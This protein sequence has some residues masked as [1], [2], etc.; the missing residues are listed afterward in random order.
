MAEEDAKVSAE[1]VAAEK[2]IN[3]PREYVIDEKTGKIKVYKRRW[4]VCLTIGLMY[5]SWNMHTSRQVPIAPAYAKYFDIPN[6]SFSSQGLGVDFMSV[7]DSIIL[8]VAYFPG[9]YAIDRWGL[10][11]TLVGGF[12]IMASSWIWLASG[13]NFAGVLVGRSLASCVGTTVSASILAVSN[14]WFPERERALATALISLLSLLGSGAALVLADMFALTDNEVVDTTLKSCDTSIFSASQLSELA[15]AAAND[16]YVDCLD[17]YADA[18]D[19]FCCYQ[20]TDIRAFNVMMAVVPTVF[21]ILML[22]SVRDLPPTAPSAAGEPKDYTGLVRGTKMLFTNQRFAKLALSD[23]I[24][25]GPVLVIYSSIS[26][27]FPAEISSYSFLASAAG[28]GLAIPTA[29]IAA[30]YMEKTKRFYTFAAGGYTLGTMFW[31]IATISYI[32]DT[33]AGHWAFF[34]SIVFALMVFIAWQTAVY[35]TKLEYVFSAHTSLE[36][37]ITGWDR[38]VINLSNLVFVSA[39][40]PEVVGSVDLTFIIGGIIMVIGCI[41]VLAIKD[42]FAYLRL[43]YDR[44]KT[45]GDDI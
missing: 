9:A 29:I 24:V 3:P 8:L 34:T 17:D 19:S 38:A 39:L 31:I 12:A 37:L 21:F 20:P 42:R 45:A 11:V 6:E 5:A 30:Y 14:R 27:V 16:T 2:E 40:A 43:A 13:T 35:E 32:A 15:V 25:S 23:F 10:K 36:G 22:L 44:S 33:T 26:R 4:A 1:V 7:L 28:I 41:P 18:K